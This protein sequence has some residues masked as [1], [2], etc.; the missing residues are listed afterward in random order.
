M[1]AADSLPGTVLHAYADSPPLTL[2]LGAL[3]VFTD[4]VGPTGFSQ[5]VRFRGWM[6]WGAG[7]MSGVLGGLVG[8]QGGIRSAAR[9]G[10]DV[11]K[12]ACVAAATAGTLI[13][14]MVGERL[15]RKLPGPIYRKVVA[16]LVLALG[17]F[18]LLQAA[19]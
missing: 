11:P 17:A 8:R 4:V 14:T 15:L 1:S 3:L 7:A 12:Q 9:L 6:A 5:R 16:A 19:Q 10:F 2:V 18:M 13:G